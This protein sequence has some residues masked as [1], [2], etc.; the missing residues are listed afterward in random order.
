MQHLMDPTLQALTI[1]N[2]ILV[3]HQKR[4]K[5]MVTVSDMS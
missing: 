4:F 1:S 2:K 5:N 3:D